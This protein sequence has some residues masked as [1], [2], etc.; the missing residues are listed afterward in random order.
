MLTI[1]PHTLTLTHCDKRCNESK[2]Y[3][4]SSIHYLPYSCVSSNGKSDIVSNF[5]PTS[6]TIPTEVCERIIDDIAAPS[7]VLESRRIY[8]MDKA[9]DTLKA[10]ALTCRA[11]KPRAQYYLFRIMRIDCSVD[12]LEGVND[13]V[14]FLNTN[15]TIRSRV[16]TLTAKGRKHDEPSTLHLLPIKLPR[17]IHGITQLRLGDGQLFLPPSTFPSL[18]HFVSITDLTLAKVTFCSLADVRRTLSSFLAVKVLQLRN[19]GWANQDASQKVPTLY[20]PCKVRLRTLVVEANR[21]WLLD[22]R[23]IYI[24]GWIGHSGMA[25]SIRNFIRKITLA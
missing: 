18:R 2:I 1:C 10:C 16:Q 9:L 21:Q 17:H 23:S 4:M 13:I 3:D 25:T 14:F 15:T 8:S 7:G 20:P 11:W 19:I 24:I 5:H 6:W 22:N 12:S